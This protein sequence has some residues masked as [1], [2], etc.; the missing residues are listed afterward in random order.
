[1]RLIVLLAVLVLSACQVTTGP[2]RV[3]TPQSAPSAP[4]VSQDVRNRFDSVVRRVGPVAVALCEARTRGRDCRFRI[5]V[6]TRPGQQPNAYQTENR[7]GRPIIVFTR[8]LVT[9]ARNTD[10][11][12]FILGHEAAHHILGHIPKSRTNAAQGAIVGAVLAGALGIEG[13]GA[14]AITRQTAT[15][16]QRSYSKEFELQADALGTVI[17]ARAGYNPVRGAAFFTRIPDPGDRFL[18]THPP[19]AERIATVR[20][21]AAGL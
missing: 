18:G 17:A 3:P 1:M 19:N 6:D 7:N 14:D 21:V 8:S 11:L 2:A 10:E 9:Q 12:A 16:A 20:R 5:I 4:P 13:A 15:I